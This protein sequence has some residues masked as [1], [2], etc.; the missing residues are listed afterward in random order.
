MGTRRGGL[1]L[2]GLPDHGQHR[3]GREEDLSCAV[4]K[5][6][7]RTQIDASVGE[8]WFCDEADAVA[9]GFRLA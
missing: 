9:A 2:V 3:R 7:A 8:K 5:Y 4:A 1:A 6:Y